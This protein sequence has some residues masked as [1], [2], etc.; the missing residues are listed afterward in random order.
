[1]NSIIAPKQRKETLEQKRRTEG[2]FMK[3]I[4]LSY[5]LK[6]YSK[7]KGN[8][9]GKVTW[10]GVYTEYLGIGKTFGWLCI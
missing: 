4:H 3:E 9:M 2:I 5:P 6:E 1:M 10:C 7:S 8:S